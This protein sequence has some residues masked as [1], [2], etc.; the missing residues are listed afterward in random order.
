MAYTL[1]VKNHNG[2]ILNLT[3]SKDYTVYKIEGLQPPQVTIATAKRS[4]S[5]GST[6]NRLSVENRNIVIYMT[7]EGDVEANRINLY[8]YFPLKQYVTIYFENGVRD[9]SIEGVVEVIECDLFTNRQ[10]AQI[11]LICPQPY[12]K[13][14]EDLITHFSSI[15]S[16]FQFPFSIAEEGMEFSTI[17]T[18]DRKAIV[19]TGDVEN[20]III[21]LYAAGAVS[22]PTVY[23]VLN[24]T[25]IKLNCDLQPNDHIVINT[26]V[27]NKAITLIRNGESS[28]AMG[29]MSPDSK[30][31]ILN[32]GDNVFTY[33]AENGSENLQVTFTT[34]LLYGGV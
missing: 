8:K 13:S 32:S 3:E 12:F 25:Y 10:V 34:A 1:K 20:G 30:W 11:S 19:N 4:V 21:D 2:Y 7:I 6:I 15:D 22:K 23:D 14:A 28:N 31:L 18:A 9:V 16:L 5:D 24:R 26:N 27:D 17:K 33:E 29:Y